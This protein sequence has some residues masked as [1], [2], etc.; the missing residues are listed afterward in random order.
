MS[1]SDLP[2]ADLRDLYENA[3]CGYL[4]LG[5]DGKIVRVNATLCSWLGRTS[6]ELIGKR[7]RDLL[8]VVGSIF[9]ET[10]FAPLLRMQGFF[11]EGGS[12]FGE[13]RWWNH[14]GAGQ[15]GR[16]SNFG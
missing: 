15:R 10:H 12:R 4:S 3:P 16:A 9:Y 13:G 2:D 5:P 11:E 8:N 6:D 1:S 7:L 14:A